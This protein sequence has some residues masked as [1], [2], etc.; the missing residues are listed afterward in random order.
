MPGF[1]DVSGMSDLQIK[2]LCQQDEDMNYRPSFRPSYRK[3]S[4][5]APVVTESFLAEDVWAAAYAATQVNGGLYHKTDIHDE[6]GVKARANRTIM[7]QYLT[8]E[9]TLS[10]L[11]RE[12]GRLCKEYLRGRILFDILKGKPINDFQQSVNKACELTEFTNLNR[13]DLAIVASQPAAY[14]KLVASD[15]ISAKARN[16][17]LV[18]TVGGKFSSAVTVLKSTFSQ[19]YGVY[20]IT[21]ETIDNNIV[22]FSYRNDCK[23]GSKFTVSGTVKRHAPDNITQLNRVKLVR[24]ED[25]KVD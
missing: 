16:G 5:P 10:D 9:L 14:I 25:N 23:I 2:R 7:M 3:T 17:Q 18:G 1:V 21:A 20:F 4:K 24:L 13:L 8:G 6:T 12:G 19:T 22:F 11:D 15:A